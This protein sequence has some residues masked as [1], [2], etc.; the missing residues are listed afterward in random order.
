MVMMWFFVHGSVRRDNRKASRVGA[1]RGV[2]GGRVAAVIDS[3]FRCFSGVHPAQQPFDQ[4][5][6]KQQLSI[7]SGSRMVSYYCINS[8]SFPLGRVFL[9]YFFFPSCCLWL[10]S[11]LSSSACRRLQQKAAASPAAWPSSW[12][13]LLSL[14]PVLSRSSVVFSFPSSASL[15]QGGVLGVREGSKTLYLKIH[16]AS[17]SYFLYTGGASTSERSSTF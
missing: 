13:L 15:L 6:K 12:P 5:Q 10:V 2:C 1:L 4:L 17:P 14:S 8:F 9:L 3:F 7:D 16:L 11:C